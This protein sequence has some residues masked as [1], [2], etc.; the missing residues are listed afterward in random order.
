MLVFAALIGVQIATGR[1]AYRYSTVSQGLLYCAYGIFCF[2]INQN[3]R[4]T[5]QVRTLAII[6]S[7]YGFVVAAFALIQSISSN[8]KLYWLRIP[9]QV[10]YMV[11][12]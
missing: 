1:S 9:R 4:R 6:L 8:G 5:R 11:P 10:G 7:V 3:L 2:L 12:T